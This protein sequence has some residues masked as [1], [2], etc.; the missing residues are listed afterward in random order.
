MHLWDLIGRYIDNPGPL[1]GKITAVSAIP[2]GD[3]LPETAS[4]YTHWVRLEVGK[5]RD[6]IDALMAEYVHATRAKC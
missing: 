1:Y 5:S 3:P 6:E 2:N 4:Q